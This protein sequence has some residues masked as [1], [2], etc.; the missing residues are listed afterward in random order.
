MTKLSAKHAREITSADPTRIRAQAQGIAQ[1]FP[2]EV[3]PFARGRFIVLANRAVANYLSYLP[4][5]RP[6][7]RK[8]RSADKNPSSSSAHR[9]ADTLRRGLIGDLYDAYMT[10]RRD[11]PSLRGFKASADAVL[12]AAGLPSVTE[13]EQTSIR[14]QIKAFAAFIKP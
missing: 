1:T 10:A 6:R 2:C 7:L 11:D 12:A 9:P 13:H 5:G 14:E 4:V 3:R 8:H